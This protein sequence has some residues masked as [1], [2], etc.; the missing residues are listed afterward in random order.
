MGDVGFVVLA[1]LG[2]AG[3]VFVLYGVVAD[4]L[5]RRREQE[6]LLQRMAEV[7][8]CTHEFEPGDGAEGEV[9]GTC[10]KCGTKLSL[11]PGKTKPRRGWT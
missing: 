7:D 10:A 6:W 1:V 11:D 2:T 4:S 3:I 5:Q 9:R 8:A